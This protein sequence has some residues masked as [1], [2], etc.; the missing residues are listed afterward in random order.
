MY[1]TCRHGNYIGDPYGVDY[2]CGQCESLEPDPSP[3]DIRQSIFEY[4]DAVK[5][6]RM[7]VR[8]KFID[9]TV[10]YGSVMGSV[11]TTAIEES[12]LKPALRD[13]NKAWDLLLESRRWAG[14]DD[15][16]N[17][18]HKRRNFYCRE[19]SIA[20]LRRERMNRE[21]MLERFAAWEEEDLGER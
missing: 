9:L 17:W 14:S 11:A 3:N 20:E 19:A 8:Q 15:D 2:M 12:T 5:R 10:K 18:M 6:A 16:Q 7:D 1:N 21:M 13:L 4:E